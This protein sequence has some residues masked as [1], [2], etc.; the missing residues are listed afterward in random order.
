M[1]QISFPNILQQLAGLKLHGGE[2]FCSQHPSSSMFP[3][4][5]AQLTSGMKRERQVRVQL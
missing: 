3:A 4:A 5:T 2:L 1:K